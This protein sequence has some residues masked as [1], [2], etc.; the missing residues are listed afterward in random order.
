[1]TQEV[2]RADYI[3]KLM[4]YRDTD[5]IKVITGMRR[6]GKSI[7][8]RQFRA[9]LE[10]TGVPKDRIIYIDMDSVMNDLYRNGRTLYS[11]IASGSGSGK[12]YVLIDEVQN[13][14]DWVR[15]VES[16]RNDI[17]CDIYITGSNAYMLSSD[18]ATILTGRS[19][20]MTVLPLSFN[21][22]MTLHGEK[23]PK[24]AFL[25]YLRHGGLPVLKPGYS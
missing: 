22:S 20:T 24:A 1:M 7:L 12:R 21:E 16:L 2:I 17:N 14:D 25:R 8:M 11:E 15:I 3:K 10:H 23:D 19:V 18:I 4:T 13:I 6:V 5:L 9:A